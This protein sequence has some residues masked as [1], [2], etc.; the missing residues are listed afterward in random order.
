MNWG[1]IAGMIML[2]AFAII[3]LLIRSPSSAAS[4]A[5]DRVEDF[6]I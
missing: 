6:Q 5:N 4:P 3:I 1:V 2:W